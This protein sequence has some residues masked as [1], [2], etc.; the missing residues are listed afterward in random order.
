MIRA[1]LNRWAANRLGSI[2]RDQRASD[3]EVIK[4][5]AQT[6]RLAMGMPA[7]PALSTKEN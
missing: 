4:A 5:K 6:M 3:R 1:W 7:H 2:A